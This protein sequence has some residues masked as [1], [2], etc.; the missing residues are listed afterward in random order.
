[1]FFFYKTKIFENLLAK[2]EYVYIFVISIFL[3]NSR[4]FSIKILFFIF[5]KKFIIGK[6]FFLISTLLIKIFYIIAEF[7]NFIK[8]F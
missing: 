6:I 1:M 7:Y 4:I 8:H 5:L 3:Y 2:N